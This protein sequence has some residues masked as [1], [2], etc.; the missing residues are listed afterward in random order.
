MGLACQALEHAP[1]WAIR[2]L[3]ATYF[4]LSLAEIGKAIELADEESVR[5]MVL[6]MVRLT[7]CTGR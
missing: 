5:E 2:K 7:L 4:T 6:S 1:R 3:T